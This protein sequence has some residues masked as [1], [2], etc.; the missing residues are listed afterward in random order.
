MLG[1]GVKH[2]RPPGK[3]RV[4]SDRNK[5]SFGGQNRSGWVEK[6]RQ[7]AKEGIKKLVTSSGPALKS[8]GRFERCKGIIMHG[9]GICGK[10]RALRLGEQ[11]YG[12]G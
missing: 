5:S 6:E 9:D 7:G 8:V 4:C 1:R 11:K 10:T 12:G 2:G 3:G